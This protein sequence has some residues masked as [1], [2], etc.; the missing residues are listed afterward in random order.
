MA[1]GVATPAGAASN[2]ILESWGY[3]AAG[4]LGNGS[5]TNSSVPTPVSLPS[6]VGVTASAAGGYHSLAIGTD[7]N[8]Y[9]WG[10]NGFG[11]LGDGTTT[12]KSNPI[13]VQLPSGVHATKVAASTDDSFA[14]GSDGNVYAWGDNSLN[15]L[16]D[17]N[18]N[19]SSTPVQVSIPAGVTVTAIAG[20]QF[21][22]LALASTG[23]VY[24]WG[25]NG[26]GQLGNGLKTTPAN[27]V[28]AVF[29]SGVT[30]TNIAAGGYHS[31]AIGSD[32]N[33]YSWGYNVDGQLGDGNKTQHVKPQLVSMPSGVSA[34]ALAA[35][36]YH[37]L[38]IGSDGKLYAWGYNLYGQIGDGTTTTQLLP[39]A[40]NL[41]SGG[42]PSAITTGQYDSLALLPNGNL[43][44][45]GQN[46]FGQ[47]GIGTTVDAWSPT[48]VTAPPLTAF[49]GLASGSGS[50]HTL[51][52]A[53]PTQTST[54]TSLT[55]AVTS[56]TFGQSE[57]LTAVVTGSDS[58]GTVAFA[59]GTS[60]ISACSAVALSLVGSS[61]QA[62]CTL[63]SLTASVHNLKATYSGDTGSSGS[64]STALP[65]TVTP[66]PLV[67]TGSSAAVTYGTS[68]APVV[69]SFAGFVN[70]DGPSALSAQPTCSTTATATSPA[71]TYPT[72]CSG[73]AGANY[74]ISYAAGQIV[75]APAPLS[76]SASSGTMFYGGSVPAITPNFV[77]FV[78]SDTPS[79]LTAAP[80]CTTTAT[81][82]SGVGSYPS[83]CTGAVDPNYVF[84]YTA[85]QVTVGAAPLLVTASSVATTYGTAATAISPSY[86]GFLNGDTSASLTTQA[87]CT[88]TATTT[89]NVGT[90][91][92]SCTGAADPNYDISYVGGTV[93]VTPAPVTVTALSTSMTYG[94]TVPTVS[95]TI[96]GLQNG[97][98]ASVL[99][100]GLACT[101]TASPASPVGAYDSSCNGAVDPNYAITYV[102]GSIAVTQA[103]LTVTASSGTMTYGGDVPAIAPT[104]AG[105]QNGEDPSV[106]GA[107]LTCGTTATTTS[108]VGEYPSSC[109]GASDPNYSITYVA[110][111]VGITP[112]PLNITASSGSSV[113][114]DPVPTISYAV[115]GLQ[116]GETSAVLGAGL[117]CETTS[118]TGSPVGAYP[119]MCSGAVDGNYTITYV[120]GIV[121][122]TAA[123]LTITASSASVTYGGSVPGVTASF[124]G[125]VNGDT[126]LSLATPPVCSTTAS[127]GSPAGTYATS[128]SSA[129][130]PNY[131][132]SY[133]SGAVVIGTADLLIVASPATMTYGD[134]TPAVTASYVGLTNG[135]TAGSLSTAPTCSTPA[136][137]SSP[138][139]SY[140]ATCSGAVD[141]NYTIS[142]VDSTVTVAPAPLTVT[143]SSGSQSY[144]AAA[145]NITPAYSGFVNGDTAT[146]L[147][148]PASCLSAALPTS[149]VGSY[150]S[151]CSGA[152]DPN[153]TIG[154]VD[155]TVAITPAALTITASSDSA[156]YGGTT[157]AI[158]P[159][160]SGLQNSEDVSVLGAGLS[161]STVATASSSVGSYP[162]TC[163]GASDSNYSISYVDGIVVVAPAAVTV[164]ASSG[165]FTYGSTPPAI[166][167]TVTGLQNGDTVSS[168]GSGL[169]CATT[170]TADT[171][172]ASYPSTCTGAVD[173]NYQISYVSGVAQ[174]MAAPLVVAAS[175]SSMTYGSTPAAVTPTY[176][177]FVN[178]EDPSV[179]NALPTCATS[180]TPNSPVGTYPTACSGASDPNYAISYVPGNVVIGATALVISASSGT[181]TYGSTPATPTPTYSGFVNGDGPGS[182]ASLPTCTA[183]AT[184]SSVVG[185][186]ATSCS[187]AV[188][189]NYTISYT[190]GSDHVVAAPLTVS[191]SSATMVFGGQKPVITPTISGFVNGDGPSVLGAG[192]SCTTAAG[193][194][195]PVGSYSSTCSGASD[196]NYSVTYTAGTVTVAPAV[197]TVTA[198]NQSMNFGSAVP[199]LTSTITG[200][201]NGQTLGTSGVTGSPACTTTATSTSTSGSYP[202]TCGPGTLS[203]GNYT[204]VF[205][206]GT[207]T[208]SSTKTLACLTFGSVTVLAGQSVRVAPGCFVIG[209]ITVN[210]GGSFDAE[211]ALVLGSLVAKGGT[212][213]LCSTSIA[214]LLSSTGATAPVVI[215]DGTSS[216]GGSILI[217]GISVN[218]GTGGVS[219]RQARALAVV[220]V[221]GNSGGVDVANNTIVGSLT[222]TGN[223]GV[224]VDHPNTVIGLSQLQ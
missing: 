43:Y 75:V 155:G 55:A 183:T 47:L 174:E 104:V 134:T 115:D 146:S 11:Q 66:A 18:G 71:A 198:N 185:S 148:T 120:E 92:S 16:G 209:S 34:T 82:S 199:T 14:L 127:T 74:S 217:G 119:S 193:P 44:A 81:S 94:G 37:S 121:S 5:S 212:V 35:G 137:S 25:Y 76:I 152:V 52:I 156:V 178:G 208:V 91:P 8:L 96:S 67:I 153:Y 27:P 6:G 224:V 138:A 64:G 41:P 109:S 117:Q 210:A 60:P 105:L 169:T 65:V 201:V 100:G 206:A 221:K 98:G 53:V 180:A 3:N 220:T 12:N 114:G 204:F 196:A 122:V 28:L 89:S 139:G 222:V 223:T 202:I 186:Y 118:I 24:G 187:G 213:R 171:P 31:L 93:T 141:G 88:T 70:G 97:E 61:E 58:G 7:G 172:V 2:Q 157:P 10:Q 22:A 83:T 184:A 125:F 219:I 190:Q 162:S 160:V 62:Q 194:T 192:L 42:T 123:P 57:T 79:S 1:I 26:N 200:F 80:T 214:L 136:T 17:G 38:A 51:A 191:A 84:S 182:L 23:K 56:P 207:L 36:L 188:D 103:A 197:L 73:A 216:C 85:G 166:T 108:P 170:A 211:G 144:G 59:D 39:E 203:A 168:L 48:Q 143:A 4:Q 195:S 131:T 19:N 163:T 147:I 126:S 110:G 142:Y 69:A 49:V 129:A 130:D 159:Q 30:A 158:V 13:V 150:D 40:I 102:D 151:S 177:G 63:S 29:P 116:N 78:N 46:G 90:Y 165:S 86:S 145:P 128:C 181:Q 45:W 173:A 135:D 215:G 179:L 154:Y 33:L 107:G 176:S 124:V 189:P 112:A 132:I 140:A 20:G 77:G 101:T 99:G 167:P 218:S 68:P 149:P 9:A 164:T 95:S 32:G 161:C 54:T 50:S 15:E 133:V 72:T 113:Y 111:T 205:V 175:S 87:S 106:L 21:H